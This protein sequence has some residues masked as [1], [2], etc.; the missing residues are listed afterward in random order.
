MLQTTGTDVCRHCN[1]LLFLSCKVLDLP[2]TL[3]AQQKVMS[4][5]T[6][7]PHSVQV[8]M[9]LHCKNTWVTLTIF[10]GCLSCI[11]VTKECDQGMLP[12]NATKLEKLE[13][14]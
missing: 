1:T 7:K 6:H 12:R 9:C 8:C 14:R 3:R 13:L 2:K 11:N 4:L 10:L 5:D